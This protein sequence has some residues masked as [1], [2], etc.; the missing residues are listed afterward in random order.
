MSRRTEDESQSPLYCTFSN[1]AEKNG[2]L[3]P[4]YSSTQNAVE[5]FAYRGQGTGL[6]NVIDEDTDGL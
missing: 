6:C 2:F 4:E 5:A 1:G 3:F